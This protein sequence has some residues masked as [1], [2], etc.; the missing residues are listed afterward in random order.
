MYCAFPGQFMRFSII[1]QLRL[2]LPGPIKHFLKTNGQRRMRLCSFVDDLGV[3]QSLQTLQSHLKPPDALE[4]QMKRTIPKATSKLAIA[5]ALGLGFMSH[6]LP[7]AAAEPQ[8]DPSTA[9]T[10]QPAAAVSPGSTHAAPAGEDLTNLSLEDLMNVQ[11][12]SAAKHTQRAAETP[13]AFTVISQED[14]QRS[15]MTS[16][17]DLLRLVPGLD[18][19]QINSNQWAI[20]S[21]GFNDLYSNKLQVLMDGRSVYTPLFSGVYWESIDYVL[22][23]LDRI[24]VVRGP[25]AT[26]WGANAVDGV[27]NITSKSAKDT[28]GWLAEGIGSNEEQQGAVRYGGQLSSDTYFRVYTKYR[29]YD[30]YET[31]NGDDANDNWQDVRGGFR[32]DKYASADDTL[33]L[34]G[35][36]YNERVAQTLNYPVLTPP[37]ISERR[38]S[39][40]DDGGNVLGRWKHIISDTSDFSLQAYYDRI[41]RDDVELGYA[42]DT[43]DIDFQHRFALNERNEL[44]WGGDVRFLADDISSTPR[45]TFFPSRRDDYLVSAF[46]Q[47]DLT[48]VP[49]R[50]HFIVGTKLEQNSYN[51]FEPEPSGRLLYTPNDRNTFW[52]AIS[53]AER[54][55]SR[56]EQDSRLLYSTTPT[57]LGL[58][59]QVDTFGVGGFTSE[60]LLAYE[61]GYRVKATQSLSF[62]LSGFYNSYDSLRGGVTGAPRFV[63]TPSPHLLIPVTLN[64]GIYGD[65]FGTELAANWNISPN[66]RVTGSY[67][68]L[69]TDLHHDN[70]TSDTLAAIYQGSSPRNQFQLHSYYDVT[71]NLELNTSLY[72]VEDLKTGNVPGYTRVDAGMTWRP[73]DALSFSLGA[74][75]I[76]DNHHPEFSS[77][78]FI[79]ATT[80]VPRTYYARMELQ[81]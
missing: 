61:L 25:G 12:Y 65:T 58:P 72:Y 57:A 41:V 54:N 62:D 15:G 55:P 69:E 59:A 2:G 68:W 79:T 48:V 47:D 4:P 73:R 74:Q 34:Q 51:G 11:V 14:I 28:Q 76:F 21:R 78:L 37:Y 29:R 24:E 13:A 56:W 66:W 46:V 67:T 52:G 30:D 9:A 81:Y 64:N 45:A 70:G 6:A 8:T 3:S 5:F 39:N 26:L 18:V 53:R 19:A 80:E 22:P 31:A 77:P 50:L 42:L 27:I 1:L 44:I 10:T 20:S 17:P 60:K 32:I 7:S 63:A 43:V 75:N 71:K 16:I 23:D 36:V 35:D 49:D 33:T 38:V 40:N